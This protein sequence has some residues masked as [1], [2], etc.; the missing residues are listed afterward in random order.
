M[1]NCAS[2]FAAVRGLKF[3]SDKTYA[4]CFGQL[5]VHQFPLFITGKPIKWVNKVKHL[6]SV[7]NSTLNDSDHV[8]GIIHDLYARANA[9]VAVIGQT[10]HVVL[11]YL[12][13]QCC[14]SLYGIESC[15]LSC[16]EIP[17]LQ[18]AWN[19]IIR[20]FTGVPYR[21]HTRL[22]SKLSGLLHLLVVAKVRMVKFS[23]RCLLSDNCIVS[24]VAR[25]ACQ[26]YNS[27]MGSN[28]IP[29]LNDG[30]VFPHLFVD[31]PKSYIPL[32]IRSLKHASELP[33]GELWKVGAIL[34]IRQSL[35]GHPDSEIL[36]AIYDYLCCG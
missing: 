29:V 21:T 35:P 5:F 31:C 12:F 17:A 36:R 26:D 28:V 15:R 14:M 30:G 20:R 8:R 33:A 22:L 13:N 2:S 19:K 7:L 9:L 11:L 4:V 34:D 16:A 10:N 18:V 1:V 25:Y 6:G 24:S 23:S 32:F 3:N 27:L